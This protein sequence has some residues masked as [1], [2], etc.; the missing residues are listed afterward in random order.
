MP[1]ETSGIIRGAVRGL[2]VWILLL[3]LF[4]MCFSLMPVHAQTIPGPLDYRI[5]VNEMQISELMRAQ[6]KILE[7][8]D[9]IQSKIFYLVGGVAVLIMKAIVNIFMGTWF[10]QAKAVK[11]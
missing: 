5:T 2:E 6:A 11:E 7:R 8:M 4:L 9:D 10:P 3:M 1:N